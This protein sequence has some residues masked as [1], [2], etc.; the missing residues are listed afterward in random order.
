M[1]IT[2][3]A[4]GA[5]VTRATIRGEI[6]KSVS[7]DYGLS[8]DDAPV[9]ALRALPS[10]DLHGDFTHHVHEREVTVKVRPCVSSLAVLEALQE[11]GA[12]TW[13]V[14]V[15]DRPD[16]DLGAAVLAHF[17]GARVRSIDPWQSAWLTFGAHGV[18]RSLAHLPHDRAIA[19]G[20]MALHHNHDQDG[21]AVPWPA[22]PGGILTR[23]HAMSAVARQWLGLA[24]GTV[25]GLEVLRWT[26]TS[27]AMARVAELRSLAGDTLANAVL[28]WLAERTG[29]SAAVVSAYLR[30]ARAQELVPLGVVVHLLRDVEQRGDAAA[31][32]AATAILGRVTLNAPPDLRRLAVA[33]SLGGLC[34]LVVHDLLA[35]HDTWA[36]GQRIVQTADQ[37]LRGADGGTMAVF[38]EVL[39]SGLSAR[40]DAFGAS[41]RE[42]NLPLAE[43]NWAAVGSHALVLHAPQKTPDG[44]LAPCL[45]A[46]R[47]ARWLALPEQ[48]TDGS[49]VSLARRQNHR[50]SWVD[51]AIQDAARGVPEGELAMALRQVSEQARDRR[52]LHDVEFAERLVAAT[53]AEE[54]LHGAFPGTGDQVLPL[55]RVVA[56]VVIPVAKLQ[57]TLLLVLDGLSTRVA[58]ELVDEVIAR[59]DAWGEYLLPGYQRRATAVS[60]LP[61]ITEVSRTSLLCGRLKAGNQDIERREHPSFVQSMGGGS[62]R[63]FHK[64][65]LDTSEDGYELAHGVAEA[66]RDTHGARLVTCVLNTI[67]DALDRSDP[68]GMDWTSNDVRHLRPLLNAA[69]QAGRAVIVTSDHGHIVERRQGHQL[70]G[71]TSEGGRVRSVGPEAGEGEVYISGSRVVDGPKI[72]AVSETLRYGPLKA[73]YHGGAAPAE[74]IVPV[75]VLGAGTAPSDDYLPAPSQRPLWWDAALPAPVA[76]LVEQVQPPAAT[77]FEP[78]PDP[79]S[80][81]ARSA[82]G[83]AVVGSQTFASQKQVAGRVR[84]PDSSLAH[85]LDQLAEMPSHRAPAAVAA[86]ILGVPTHSFMGAFAQVQKLMNVEGYPVIRNDSGT[87]VLDIA[88][89]K[90]QFGVQ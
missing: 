79:Q 88:L 40:L 57:P 23:D 62:T 70:P 45:A 1:S 75:I 24:S 64:K 22:A 56:D 87:V 13:L 29:P 78:E 33:D 7:K 89:L 27:D 30:E 37:L 20:L 25:D 67:D 3:G 34:S 21:G 84:V 18:D 5:T 68:G 83:A 74:V 58:D 65:D 32:P 76:R 81:P 31:S 77:L 49:F 66:V 35:N 2:A 17:I 55:E 51:S 47:L 90:E 8:P 72:L 69:A 61:S 36:D 28:A 52:H 9:L 12:N 39:P 50:D 6:D 80:S 86:Q 44:R 43:E 73:G 26:T 10:P 4:T 71:I 38:S 14:I 54:G 16:E 48:G 15:T 85:L 19:E 63:I 46:L 41:L 42:Q 11:R 60:V 82:L 53:S 59:P